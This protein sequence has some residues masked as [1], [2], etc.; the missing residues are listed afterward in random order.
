LLVGSVVISVGLTAV[1][2]ETILRPVSL[3]N[4]ASASE[5]YEPGEN[6]SGRWRGRSPNARSDGGWFFMLALGAAALVV[7]TLLSALNE[8]RH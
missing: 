1:L 7:G 6:Q 8:R 2:A 4:A 3:A 5:A